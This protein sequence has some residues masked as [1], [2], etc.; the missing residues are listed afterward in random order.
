MKTRQE[1]HWRDAAVLVVAVLAIAVRLIPGRV[2]RPSPL[3]LSESRQSPSVTPFLLGEAVETQPA[4]SPTGN[5]VA[6]VSDD[7]GNDDVWISDLSGMNRINLT[8]NY[9]GEDSFPAWSADGQRIAFYS[10]RDGG[11]IYT[12]TS[13]GSDVRK[14][15][16]VPPSVEYTFSLQW[17]AKGSIVYTN[18][19]EYGATEVYR[20]IGSES[21]P[22]CLTCFKT[23]VRGARSGQLSPSGRLLAF[24]G[25]SAGLKA[26]VSVLDLLAGK[27]TVLADLSDAPHWESDD[28]LIFLSAREG[29]SDLW[30]ISVNPKTGTLTGE[31]TR[32]TSGLNATQFAVSDAGR[33]IV[34]VKEANSSLWVFPTAPD[35]IDRLS[36]GAP[37][38]I[39]AFRDERPRWSND[40][41]EVCF[42]SNRRG[43]VQIW[44]IPSAGGTP[45][46]LP[47]SAGL[48]DCQ[49]P[50]PDGQWLE[51][52]SE[53]T[54][55]WLMRPD[56]SGA[57]QADDWRQEYSLVANSDWSPLGLRLV[58]QLRR[59]DG[60]AR[61][62]IAEV[63]A[64]TGVVTARRELDATGSG[65]EHPRWSPDGRSVVCETFS[66]S[67]NLWIIDPERGSCRQ[68]TD[69]PGNERS[70]VWQ[71]HPLFVYF[72]KDQRSLWR[73]PMS[74]A[75]TPSGPPSPWL[76]LPR[77][78][79]PADSIDI[80]HDGKR[81]V[82]ALSK[83]GTDLWLVERK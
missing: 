50:S 27:V 40:G 10:D 55:S 63:N 65:D 41:R 66:G 24:V 82:V 77:L 12:M 25:F 51:F 42:T 17:T 75:L 47:S 72:I 22:Q 2:S 64:A 59:L 74:D 7:V 79:V 4:W 35:R 71:A 69:L 62:G 83:T 6:Y 39:G 80:S 5:L 81:L 32:V 18:F 3:A 13:L 73:I 29:L 36:L 67:W 56:G 21:T 45:A 48:G 19:D 70:A 52:D 8:K 54:W 23:P 37:L 46:L 31:P 9:A 33:R 60:Q 58:S 34:A 38:T 78:R 20:V 26:H 11:G 15:A 68:V 30:E 16:S 76:V 44:T 28:R 61:V 57:H 53:G 49:R 1:D 14:V 43:S